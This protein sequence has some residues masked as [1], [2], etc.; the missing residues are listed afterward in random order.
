[1]TFGRCKIKKLILEPSKVDDH[2]KSSFWNR[3]RRI[4]LPEQGRLRFKLLSKTPSFCYISGA[5]RIFL[6]IEIPRFFVRRFCEG[7][8]RFYHRFLFI[9]HYILFPLNFLLIS[10]FHE[11]C[12]WFI[13]IVWISIWRGFPLLSSI[14]WCDLFVKFSAALHN[15]KDIK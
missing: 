11:I 13:C 8:N 7:P 6:P 14:W 1:M 15:I 12:P 2:L 4:V 10:R 9:K 5:Y 3:L